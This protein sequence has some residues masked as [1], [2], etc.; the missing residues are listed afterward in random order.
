MFDIIS[1]VFRVMRKPILFEPGKV[2]NIITLTCV[3]VHNFLRRSKTSSSK[4]SPNGI[5]YIENEEGQI[6]PGTWGQ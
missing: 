2:T 1:S 6:I 3:L 4:Y 5:F